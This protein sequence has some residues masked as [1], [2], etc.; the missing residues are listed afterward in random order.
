MNILVVDDHMLIRKGLRILLERMDE[1]TSVCEA[2]S[3][4]EAV[5]RI[6]KKQ[7]D[8]VIMDLSMPDG[9]D[10][11]TAMQHIRSVVPTTKVIILTMHDQETYVR[12]AIRLKA[13]G[14]ILKNSEPGRIKE[15][16]L[17]VREG[18]EYYDPAIP[19]EM[20]NRHKKSD[21]EQSVLTKRE[22]EVLRFVSL[23]YSN[24]QIAEQLMIS[25]KTV[26]RHKENMM[27]KLELKGQHELVQY[28]L[29]NNYGTFL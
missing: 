24:R 29:R 2:E 18:G 11:F 10:G 25:P 27:K 26:E 1:V 23:G 4:T 28:G 7:P 8:I 16:I 20:I 5:Q 12:R 22:Q 6:Y 15:A 3:G 13:S 9:L 17:T 21:K 14:Y 19:Q